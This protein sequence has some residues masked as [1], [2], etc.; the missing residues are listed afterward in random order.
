MTDH[1]CFNA[2]HITYDFITA[3]FSVTKL[4]QLGQN[5]ATEHQTAS[6][7]RGEARWREYGVKPGLCHT[8]LTQ[9]Y[10]ACR[11]LDAARVRVVHFSRGLASSIG[12]ARCWCAGDVQ[13]HIKTTTLEYAC[14]RILA[15]APPRREPWQGKLRPTCFD[16]KREMRAHCCP[17]VGADYLFGCYAAT[18]RRCTC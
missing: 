16:D 14:R 6:S 10:A 1:G 3:S 11:T 7:R 8:T 4:H 17:H 2:A 9:R 18:L 12:M 5:A 15:A 13:I